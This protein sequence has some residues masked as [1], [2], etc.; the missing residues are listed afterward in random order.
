MM[1]H[2][3]WPI[4]D[5]EQVR[6]SI[7][8]AYSGGVDYRPSELKSTPPVTRNLEKARDLIVIALGAAIEGGD[9]DG[10]LP[11]DVAQR[12]SLSLSARARKILLDH[13]VS[14][15]NVDSVKLWL[16]LTVH[17]LNIGVIDRES[18]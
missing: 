5:L 15:G 18:R 6:E 11:K 8:G 17:M 2:P 3:L 12:W 13:T 14:H 10:F 7:A 16:L 4:L 1:V 9:G